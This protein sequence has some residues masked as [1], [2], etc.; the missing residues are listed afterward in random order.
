MGRIEIQNLPEK[1]DDLADEDLLVLEDIDDTKKVTLSHLKSAF[2]I[3]NLIENAK[4]I[5]LDKINTFMETHSTR[6]NALLRRN[7][8]LEETCNT[9]LNET[10]SNKATIN[11]LKNIISNQNTDIDNLLMQKDELFNLIEILQIDRDNL[12]LE[13]EKLRNKLSSNQESIS[14]LLDQID[15]LEKRIVDLSNLSTKL[16]AEVNTLR[17]ESNNTVNANYDNISNR[18]TE[19]INDIIAYI[20]YYHPDVDDIIKGMEG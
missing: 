1:I 20:R 13:L 9:L 18:L 7:S 11:Q 4:G 14:E 3:N 19:N 12:S 10:N 2:S 17:E 6:Y 5:L 15:T 8:L 16:N